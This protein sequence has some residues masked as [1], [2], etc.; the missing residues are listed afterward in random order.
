MN[1]RHALVLA[2]PLAAAACNPFHRDPVSEV[3][4]D[5]DVK[6]R[7]RPFLE[8]PAALADA[9]QMQAPQ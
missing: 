3:R 7:W 1:T 4:R 9:V 2:S 8:T 6:S 5:V